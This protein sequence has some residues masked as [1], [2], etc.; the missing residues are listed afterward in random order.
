[1]YLYIDTTSKIQYGILDKNFK[2]VD[3]KMVDSKKSS[4]ELHFII[5][6]LNEK[7]GIE[8][9]EI[10][11]IFYG[12]GP[13]SY[14]GMRVSEGM[15]NIFEWQG[16]DYNSFYHFEIPK[17]CGHESGAWIAKAFK[18]EFFVYSWDAHKAENK[19][20][21]KQDFDL[22]IKQ[23]NETLYSNDKSI[24][25]GEVIDTLDLIHQESKKVFDLINK[26]NMK[27]ELF[28]Y[29][30]IDLEFTRAK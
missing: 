14:T 17:I 11:K 12:A 22:F 24:L 30:P 13:G 8:L 18:G 26:K 9:N 21:N 1:M 19:L 28:Y 25:D 7:N 6:E 23:N 29:R 2:W 20:L 16:F 15:V 3:F 10:N 4:A 27:Q 5:H